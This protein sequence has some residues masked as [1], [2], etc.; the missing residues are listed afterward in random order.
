MDRFLKR[1]PE[2]LCKIALVRVGAIRAK[3]A[4]VA[5]LLT[6]GGNY[7]ACKLML[8]RREKIGAIAVSALAVIYGVALR[9]AGGRQ[10]HR[11]KRVLG[12]RQY[13]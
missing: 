7:L 2:R 8:E 9:G 10:T 1:M 4:R 5:A 3:I 6:V 12:S 11:E 13:F